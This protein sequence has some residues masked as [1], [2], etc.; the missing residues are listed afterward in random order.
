MLLFD[1]VVVEE[2]EAQI[3]PDTFDAKPFGSSRFFVWNGL[4]LHF[5]PFPFRKRWPQHCW[6]FRFDRV[7]FVLVLHFQNAIFGDI[8]LHQIWLRRWCVVYI[9][10]FSQIR[11]ISSNRME[12]EFI[13]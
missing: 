6:P 13:L 10:H 7:G 4:P 11:S 9:H 2:A 3:R 8:C 1:A 5:R 12:I